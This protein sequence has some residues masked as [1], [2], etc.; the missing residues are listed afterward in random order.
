MTES[1]GPKGCQSFSR[2]TRIQSRTLVAGLVEAERVLLRVIV[3]E[4]AHAPADGR[5]RVDVRLDLQAVLLTE[6][7]DTTGM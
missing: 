4:E 3:I 1:R 6:T 2:S 5:V 7:D